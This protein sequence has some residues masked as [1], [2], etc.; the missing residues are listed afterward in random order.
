V[1]FSTAFVKTFLLTLSL[2]AVSAL[3]QIAAAKPERT[4]PP[5]SQT[6]PII[7]W[8]ESFRSEMISAPDPDYPSWVVK[9]GYEGSG[10]F[11]VHIRDDGT[12][13]LVKVFHTTGSDTLDREAIRALKRWKFPPAKKW[14]LVRVPINFKLNRPTKSVVPPLWGS[15]LPN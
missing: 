7:E 13:S 1:F 12:V 8:K 15:G 5:K 10:L 3:F 9:K 4:A 2:S 14:V 6:A 11:D